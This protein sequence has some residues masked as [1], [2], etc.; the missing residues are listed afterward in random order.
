[1][2]QH[3]VTANRLG[4]GGV[5]YLST[6]GGWTEWLSEADI[7]DSDADEARLLAI[8]ERAVAARLVVAPYAIPVER[9][10]A[11]LKALSQRERIRAKGPTIHPQFCKPEAG[12]TGL[13]SSACMSTTNTT[14]HW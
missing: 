6:A 14:A 11:S 2:A 3:V 12:G 7:V 8:A 1:M 9:Q 13:E 10:G 5:V 4:D